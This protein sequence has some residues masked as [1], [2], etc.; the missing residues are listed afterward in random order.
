MQQAKLSLYNDY[1]ELELV[2]C[3]GSDTTILLQIWFTISNG[4]AY[5]IGSDKELKN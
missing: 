3:G 1:M 2:L 5:I 4:R